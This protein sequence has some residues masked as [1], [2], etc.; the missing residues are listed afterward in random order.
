MQIALLGSQWK[1]PE[2]Y[3]MPAAKNVGATNSDVVAYHSS[4]IMKDW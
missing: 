2:Q 4:Y 3:E 1:L